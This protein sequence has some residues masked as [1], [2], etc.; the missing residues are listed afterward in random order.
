MLCRRC[1]RVVL[2]VVLCA[3]CERLAAADMVFIQLGKGAS[4]CSAARSS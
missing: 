2:G 3:G 4:A 1:G